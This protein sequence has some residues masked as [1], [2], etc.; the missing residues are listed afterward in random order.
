MKEA[1]PSATAVALAIVG[2]AT[3]GIILSSGANTANVIVTA[4]QTFARAIRCAMGPIIGAQ[5]DCGSSS[6]ASGVA[7]STIT[8]GEQV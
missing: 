8:F 2:V 7:N 5:S 4:G 3:L 1:L 6:V